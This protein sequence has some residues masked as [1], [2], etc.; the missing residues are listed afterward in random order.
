MFPKKINLE[1]PLITKEDIINDLKNIGLKKGMTVILHSSLSSLGTVL[2]G[3]ITVIQ[4]LMEM[5]TEEGN[6][7]MPAHSSDNTNPENWCNP[8]VPK[9]WHKIIK[10]KMPAF[11]SA[12]YPTRQMGVIADTFLRFP[13]VV[14]SNH[15]TASFSAWGKDKEKIIF[16]HDL[17]SSFGERSP[18]SKVYDL[19]GYVLL[20]G[21]SYNR[22]TSFHLSEVRSGT[23]DYT[24]EESAIYENNIRKWKKYK[25]MDYNPDEFINIG[26]D[27]EK[28]YKVSKG[29]IGLADS[30]FFNQK[31]AVDFCV[32]WLK[33][34][35]NKRSKNL[36]IEDYFQEYSEIFPFSGTILVAKNEEIITEMSFGYSDLE[37][38]VRNKLNTK[39]KI[40][41]ITKIFTAVAILKLFEKNL[42]K[43]EDPLNNYFPDYFDENCEITIS[44]LLNHTSGI[45]N[46]NDYFED[47]V[48][49]LVLGEN[50]ILGSVIEKTL[51]FKPGEDFEYSNTNYYILG[52][53]IE[54][55]TEKSYEEYIEEIILEPLKMN[56]TGFCR[57]EKIVE[58]LSKPY[59]F[60]GENIKKSL[61]IKGENF[62][63]AGGLYSTAKD[64][65]KFYKAL[66]NKEI[67]SEKSFDQMIKRREIYDNLNKAF[68]GYGIKVE[69]VRK[70]IK[71]SHNGDLWGYN[72]HF[73][74][75]LKEDINIIILSNYAFVPVWELTKPIYD[76][77]V[78]DEYISPHKPKRK[79]IDNSKIESF[80]GK[81][82]SENKKDIIE[83]KYF[84]EKYW[85]KYNNRK[86]CEVYSYSANKFQNTKID[87]KYILFEEND[88]KF[89]NEFK[90]IK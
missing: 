47:E 27:F 73:E 39:F 45:K 13:G 76:V 69:K 21:V 77:L 14:R 38:D 55:I 37:M 79:K 61:N 42:I 44:N 2:G 11:D 64:L 23:I 25:D 28:E 43:L 88:E 63:A 52:L 3:A 85:I 75:Y 90:K 40:A 41:S 87:E 48:L 49:T 67:L 71:L 54:K 17:E 57:A 36:R 4:A 81:Y 29:K 51:N 68:Y 70:D 86:F 65:F 62:Y 31:E 89:I 1:K 12:Y 6:I 19:D 26:K 80:I 32:S 46:Y 9:E 22:N 10:E 58:N 78:Y 83:F 20:M 72:S 56:D 30:L 66:K 53:I 74:Y 16:D 7:V 50:E 24:N 18:L 33:T 15:P 35:K 8:P 82:L 59:F 84:D 5:I 60:D 34:K